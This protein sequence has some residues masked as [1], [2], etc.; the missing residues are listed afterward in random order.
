M[1]IHASAD[2]W[3]LETQNTAYALG[4]NASGMLVHRYWGPRLP[5]LLDYPPV[6]DYGEWSSFYGK[7]EINLEEY[8]VY[9]G[10]TYREPCLKATF[11]DG[12]RDT[13]LEFKAAQIEGDELKIVLE[14]AHYPLR[15]TLHYRILE[16]LDLFERWVTVENF[17]LKN[18][19]LENSGTGPIQL[20]RVLSA[21]WHLPPLEDYRLTHLGGRW[22]EEFQVFQEPLTHGVKVLESRRLTSGHQNYPWFAL[23]NRD[24]LEERGEVWF[25]VLAWSGNWK[26]TLEKTEFHSTRASIGLNDWDFALILE[27]G[28]H[29]VTPKSVAGYSSAGFGGASR[30]LHRFVRGNLPHGDAPHK[31][32]YNSW[33][34]TFF[35]VTEAGQKELAKI[36]A[37]IG[38]ELFVMDDGWFHGRNSDGAGLG[39]WWPDQTKFPNGLNPLIERVNALGMDFGLWLEPEMV[40]PD[41]DLYRA[42]PDWAIHFPTRKRTEMRNQLIL[43]LAKLEVQDYL[44]TV[45]DQLLSSHNIRFIK[46]DM[47]RNATEPGW[48]EAKEPRELWVRY[49]EGFYRVWDTLAARHPRITFQSCSGGGGRAD[50]GML[51][52]ADQ[53]WLS[54][55]TEPGSRLKIQHGAS[56]ALPASVQEAW[57]TDM[58]SE[59]MPPYGQG[60]SAL[61]RGKMPL[62]FRFHVSMCGTLGVGA[63]LLNWDESERQQAAELIALYKEIRPVVQNGDLYR[64]KSPLK[65]A[66]SALE[67]LGQ[68]G[69]EGVLFA[70]RTHL[71]EP[72]VLP[73]VRLAGLEPHTLYRVDGL[74]APLSGAV[75]MAVGLTLELKDFSSVVRRFYRI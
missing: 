25:G 2:S 19:G 27:P 43:N 59:R 47:N 51:T 49:V 14:D 28:K 67:Y 26:A 42:H 45:L 8:P 4:F 10:A 75:L 62:E 64:L 36:A 70:F 15:V 69:A 1:P 23:D 63:N 53:V 54:D 9:G 13:V 21:Q 68:D 22:L 61:K 44:I 37:C 11:T 39:D 24:A 56:Y 50:V 66:F 52:R 60:D 74:D 3:I 57:V 48:Q 6:Q 72:I 30:A 12:V 17:G 31:V 5:Y 41:S 29:F 65:G 18:S 46:W 58:E 33:E 34:A 38:V 32:L 73:P 7:R 40:N 16:D 35:D 71:S 55:N 20:E